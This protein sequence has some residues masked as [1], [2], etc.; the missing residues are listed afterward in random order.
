MRKT[1]STQETTLTAIREQLIASAATETLSALVLYSL[2][3]VVRYH[4]H[5]EKGFRVVLAFVSHMMRRIW[6]L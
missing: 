3:E 5:L 1:R 6:A 2:L 4:A